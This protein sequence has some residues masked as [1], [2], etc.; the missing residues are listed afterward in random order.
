MS[1]QGCRTYETYGGDFA[2]LRAKINQSEGVNLTKWDIACDDK[3]GLLNMRKIARVM[4]AKVISDTPDTGLRSHCEK[5]NI[6]NDFDFDNPAGSTLYIG[7][8]K[9]DMRVRIYDK[10]KQMYDPIK[11]PEKYNSPWV[12]VEIVLKKRY[13]VNASLEMEKREDLGEF[14][15]EILNGY[16]AFI[17]L[18]DSNI[19]RCTLVDW[20]AEFLERTKKVKLWSKGTVQQYFDK[21]VD[22]LK[23]KIGRTIAM[24]YEGMGSLKFYDE[25]IYQNKDKLSDKQRSILAGFRSAK[26]A[27]G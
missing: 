5:R 8:K 1:G 24:V 15:A 14:V 26:F 22:W 21:T 16:M 4:L 27:P 25:I 13:A 20:W 7:S 12:R 10:A 19:S 2:V 18:D 6:C 3:S 17:N 11:E 9:S 23:H